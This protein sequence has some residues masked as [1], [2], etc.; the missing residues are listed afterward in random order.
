[1]I[2]NDT[3]LIKDPMGPGCALYDECKPNSMSMMNNKQCLGP[4]D[5]H[6]KTMSVDMVC[7]IVVRA[8]RPIHPLFHMICVQIL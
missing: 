4:V 2:I 6:E 3:K 1:M 8:V 7:G 5:K